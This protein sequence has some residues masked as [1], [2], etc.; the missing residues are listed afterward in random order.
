MIINTI[1]CLCNM[2]YKYYLTCPMPMVERRINYII[3]KNPELISAFD[4]NTNYPLIRKY[5]NSYY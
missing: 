5:K 1:S 4:R 3:A 2:I